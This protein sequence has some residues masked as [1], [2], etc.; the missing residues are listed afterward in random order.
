MRGVA[1]LYYMYMC[2]HMCMS[3]VC[4][5]HA[6]VVTGPV[7]CQSLSSDGMQVGCRQK[8]TTGMPCASPHMSATPVSVKELMIRSTLGTAAACSRTHSRGC[9]VVCVKALGGYM[10]LQP[11]EQ[12]KVVSRPA[13]AR[14]GA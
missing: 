4:N 12:G 3:T 9:N 5:V 10:A 11:G 7:A 14:G 1:A 13:A 6:H 2:M 8:P